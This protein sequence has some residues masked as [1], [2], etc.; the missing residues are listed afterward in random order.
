MRTTK[1]G[2]I[3]TAL[4]MTPM[5]VPSTVPG[6]LGTAWSY[7]CKVMEVKKP[8][9]GGHCEE[10]AEDVVGCLGKARPLGCYWLTV[11]TTYSGSLFNSIKR[12]K[13]IYIVHFFYL[14]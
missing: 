10:G 6:V 7:H 4:M 2:R 14:N 11:E 8:E 5:K 9:D 3:K 12:F 1:K 13:K